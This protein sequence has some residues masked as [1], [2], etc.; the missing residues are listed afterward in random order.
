MINTITKLKKTSLV[1]FKSRKDTF[2]RI[3]TLA[4]CGLFIGV[5][6]IPIFSTR[7]YEF[8]WTDVL[9]LL[10]IGLLL[11]IYF[12]TEYELTRSELQYKSGP[13]RGKIEVDKIREIIKGKTMW[14]GMKTSNCEKWLDNQIWK[15]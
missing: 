15:I 7:E 13:L 12:Q 11:W 4:F 1:K 2:F 14:S 9:L 5:I 8:V 6:F 3:F 10:G